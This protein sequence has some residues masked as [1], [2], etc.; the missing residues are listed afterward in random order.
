VPTTA[1]TPAAVAGVTV[2]RS[3]GSVTPAQAGVTELA[4][5]GPSDGPA[6]PLGILLTLVG[7]AMVVVGV[8]GARLQRAAASVDD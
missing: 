6:L 2:I 3:P 1:L 4:A 5:T 8:R 7:A